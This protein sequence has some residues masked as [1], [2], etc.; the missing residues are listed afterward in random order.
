MQSSHI[1]IDKGTWH[2]RLFWWS[3]SI[4]GAWK[5]SRGDYIKQYEY[6]TT[7]YH[8]LRTL[9]LWMPLAIVS[10]LATY[11]ALFLFLF[12]FPIEIKGLLEYLSFLT[13]ICLAFG[14]FNLGRLIFVKSVQE[15][16]F[17]YW[18]KHFPGILVLLRKQ[19]AARIEE[20]RPL[21][22]FVGNKK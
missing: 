3:L 4:I 9:F 14:A 20:S 16:S 11:V 19:I 18:K 22:T 10:S 8:Y 6:G 2:C 17:M 21:I 5:G 13:A 1:V 12:F 7:L 15:P